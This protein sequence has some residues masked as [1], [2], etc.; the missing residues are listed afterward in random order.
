[1]TPNSFHYTSVLPPLLIEYFNKELF[2][3]LFFL[4]ISISYLEISDFSFEHRL[5]SAT[6]HLPHKQ[7]CSRWKSGNDSSS[8]PWAE[9]KV[10]CNQLDKCPVSH[11]VTE[12]GC[13][14]INWLYLFLC[15]VFMQCSLP[16]KAGCLAVTTFSCYKFMSQNQ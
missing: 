10:R 16:R 9:P 11:F 8:C 5:A 13:K 15:T 6:F 14:L 12:A 7:T 2:F 3:F 4:F 1:M